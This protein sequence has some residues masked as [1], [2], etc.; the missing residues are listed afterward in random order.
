MVIRVLPASASGEFVE[1]RRERE[2]GY[3]DEIDALFDHPVI[4][5]PMLETDVHGVGDL[6]RVIAALPEE[7]A[8]P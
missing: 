7:A 4:R 6:R 2:Q 5:V 8:S 1:R 3:L